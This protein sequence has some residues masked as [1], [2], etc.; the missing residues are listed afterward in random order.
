M[1]D[2]YRYFKEN[3]D[4]LGLPAPDT[5]FSSLQTAVANASI[6]LTQIDKFGKAVTV[7]ELLGAGT[8]LEKLGSVAALS[9][10]FYVGAVIGSIA[11]ATGRTMSGGTSISDVLFTANRYN[12]NRPWLFP[13][14]VRSPGL[15][16]KERLAKITSRFE[17][18]AA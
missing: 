1:T 11:V 15:Y 16:R 8:K 10:A 6:L 18:A 4:G 3:M 12:L 2:F 14:L 5:L 9:A 7:G 17:L 13:M